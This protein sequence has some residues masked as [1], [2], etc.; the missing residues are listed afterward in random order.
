MDGHFVPNLTVGPAVVEAIRRAS[1]LPLDV[2]LM[3]DH[4]EQCLEAFI[5]AGASFLTVHVES[6]GLRDERAL[7]TTLRAARQARV[8]VGL[9]VR[10]ATAAEA[11]KPYLDELDLILVMT[12][13]PGFGGQAFMPEVVPKIRQL[14]AW[15]AGHLSVDGGINAIRALRKSA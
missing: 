9:S 11:V 10:P 1:Q 14:R 13:E 12:V 3:V 8:G 5:R 4:P 6:Q 15:F 2:H 7:R